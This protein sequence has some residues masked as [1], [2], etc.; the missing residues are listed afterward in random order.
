[1]KRYAVVFEVSAQT[2]VRDDYEPRQYNFQL[3]VHQ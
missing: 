1:M 2:D 3:T